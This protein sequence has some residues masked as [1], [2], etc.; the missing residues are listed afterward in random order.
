MAVANAEVRNSVTTTNKKTMKAVQFARAGAKLEMVTREIPQPKAG[1]V[2][3]RVQACGIC[4][5]DSLPQLGVFPGQRYPMVP[6]HEVV[7]T[8]DAVGDGINEWRVGQRVGVGWHGGH[9]FTCRACRRGD[10]ILCENGLIPGIN[11]DGGYAEYMVARRESLAAVPEELASAEAGPLMCAGITT[12]NALRNAHA[13]PG[14]TVAVLGIGGLGHLG[15]QYSAKMG[16]RTVAIARGKDKEKFA[17]ELG[18]HHYIDSKS[19]DPA[20]TLTAL[21]GAKVILATVTN[22]DAM[23]ATIDGLSSDGRLLVIG[24]DAAPIKVSPFQLIGGRKGVAGWPSGTAIDSEDTLRFS[25]MTG[26]RPIIERYPLD[27]AQEAFDRMMSGDARF[28][29]VLEISNS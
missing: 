24:A 7:G 11:M 23:A 19:E 10:F 25:A 16:F 15:V 17:R 9:D 12:F 27:R 2:R 29:V 26:V 20:K 22:S 18:A 21:G 6:G 14:D 13:R 8:I 4:H 5:S 3:I 28:R 1:E